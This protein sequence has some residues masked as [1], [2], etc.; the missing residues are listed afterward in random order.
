MRLKTGVIS[1]VTAVL[2]VAAAYLCS[3][4]YALWRVESDLNEGAERVLSFIEY[5]TEMATESLHQLEQLNFVTCDKAGQDLLQ[6]YA[7]QHFIFDVFLLPQLPSRET[8][9]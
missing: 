2:A 3:Y 5:K 7:F 6:K 9:K 8:Q 4:S 1:F